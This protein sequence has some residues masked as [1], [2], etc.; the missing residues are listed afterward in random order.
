VT[1][2]PGRGRVDRRRLLELG[3]LAA[4][5]LLA[6]WLRLPGL[7]QRGQWDS[8][9]GRDMAV[10]QSMTQGGGI[11]LLGP[12]TS[13]GGIHHGAVYY[14]LLAPV[15][16]ISGSDPVAVT[17]A[18][19]LAGLLAVAAIAWLGRLVAG[20]AAGIAAGLLAAVSPS[21][22]GASIFL[23]EP[24][25]IPAAA[26]VGVAGV[27]AA[28][29]SGQARW[30]L[31]AGL[32]VSLAMQF[33]VLDVVLVVPVA[34]AWADDLRRRRRAGASTRGTVRG[35]LGAVLL[36]ALGYL[37]LAIHELT[38]GFSE[39]HALVDFIT[40]G[41]GGSGTSTGIL[42]RVVV[43]MVR[44]LT[45]PLAGL[46]TDRP[47]ASLV[48]LVVVVALGAAAYLLAGRRPAPV[49]GG[50]AARADDPGRW[51]A[52]WLIATLAFSVVALGVLAPSLATVTPGLP[53]DHYHAF[54]DPIVLALAAA[55][56]VR[57]AR[58]TW[59]AASPAAAAVTASMARPATAR[60]AAGPIAGA[61][62]AAVLA[63]ISVISWP[64]AV[65]PDGGW[66]LADAA[67]AHV[68]DVVDAGWPASEPRLLVSLPSF[69]P[70]DAMRFPL[71]R[72]GFQ[73]Q[74][75]VAGD[76]AV[77]S[78]PTG[79]V[80]VVCDP[81][82]DDSTGAPCGGIAE[83]RW[84]VSAY[85]PG[86]MALVERFRAGSRRVISIYAP[87]RLAAVGAG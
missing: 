31:V 53:N 42:E 27:L 12:S 73:L 33:H 52:G 15:A 51:P 77:G 86:T 58:A 45:W 39:L 82:F 24:N 40:T 44:S 5:L 11:P 19:A 70:D 61:I 7:D 2:P 28:R 4:V 26:A 34:W 74:P 65:S 75:P 87:S 81:L 43:V 10:L 66:L 25:L 80:T 36:I 68:I 46:V 69:K 78:L 23:W 54:L 8:D 18:I 84:M 37:P 41:G 72:W 38:S 9:Q 30:W 48:A 83:D 14:Y 79:V 21:L 76:V 16:A 85:P 62:L 50:E 6:A 71:E 64:P 22:I 57:L 55:G 17:G 35:G 20:P 3:L 49:A 60:R 13:V 59:R 56:S 67:A 1:A 47:A 63:G 29:A 32:G